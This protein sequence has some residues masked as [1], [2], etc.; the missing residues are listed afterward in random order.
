MGCIRN[1][2]SVCG[3]GDGAKH[4]TSGLYACTELPL[5]IAALLLQEQQSILNVEQT[6]QRIQ[7]YLVT[8]KVRV[9]VEI[10]N[11]KTEDIHTELPAQG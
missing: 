9:R 2:L 11:L 10:P 6:Q 4:R 8:S 5:Y 1:V 3:K 7:T